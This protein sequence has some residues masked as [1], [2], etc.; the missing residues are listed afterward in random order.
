VAVLIFC[1]GLVLQDLWTDHAIGGSEWQQGDW[2]INSLEAN[3][4]R[5][6]AGS[7]II[8]VSDVLNVS[9]LT[10]VVALQALLASLVYIFL[11]WFVLK[12]RAD[13]PVLLLLISPAA[14]PV[15]W[16]AGP[17][18]M[19][20]ELLAIAAIAS[21]LPAVA[22]TAWSRRVAISLSL[23]F[24]LAGVLAHEAL[25]VFAPCLV[26]TYWLLFK[27]TRLE[28][29]GFGLAVGASVGLGF[30]VA[31]YY[32]SIPD[33][34]AV[35]RPLLDR[36]LSRHICTGAIS[37]LDRSLADEMLRVL[38]TNI[39]TTGFL[40]FLVNL[41]IVS[42]ILRPVL[43]RIQP[44]I[45]MNV[46][47]SVA[48]VPVLPLYVIAIDWGR[49][50][51]FQVTALVLMLVAGLSAGRFSVDRPISRRLATCLFCLSLVLVPAHITGTELGG[52][53][54]RIVTI[55]LG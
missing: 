4:R 28:F 3:V 41:T 6:I 38:K 11:V 52:V 40:G 39:L 42:L 51:N 10:V 14:A 7:A 46:L 35:C 55:L 31:L 15:F 47:L 54:E 19:R 17:E 20:K 29:T 48:V 49:W 32:P 13:A 9:P 2:L 5:G 21:L 1:L 12:M 8:G 27:P 43:G 50:L 16:A 26:M 53:A 22:T 36:G 45:C 34:G 33:T 44:S 30:A 18:A 25:V 37:V 24:F 23:T